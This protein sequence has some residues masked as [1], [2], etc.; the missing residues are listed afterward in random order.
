M[1]RYLKKRG[2]TYYVVRRVPEDVQKL[3]GSTIF[4]ESL[5]T[6]D[7]SLARK[8]RDERLKLLELEWAKARQALRVKT[9]GMLKADELRE[10]LELRHGL[11][12]ESDA[13][14]VDE[15]KEA[16]GDRT[17]ELYGGD[18]F[19]SDFGRKGS[20]KAGEFYGIASGE[21]TPT[22]LAV[23]QFLERANLKPSTK[24][25]YRKMLKLTMA[26]FPFLEDITRQRALKFLRGYAENTT[27]KAVSNLRTATRSLLAFHG[28]DP[29]VM[30]HHRIDAGKQAT[31]KGVWTDEEVLRLIGESVPT[32]GDQGWLRDAITVAAYSG[33]R[34]QEVCGLVYDADKDQLVVVEKKAKTKS[35]VRRVPCHP[36]AR[37]AVKR[38]VALPKPINE[39]TLTKQT[40]R[41]AAKLSIPQRI[42]IDGVQ[43][44]R[45]FHAFRHTFASKLTSLG[46]DEATIA[47]IV[48]HRGG[49]TARYAGKVDPEL[50]RGTVERVSYIKGYCQSIH[51][52][53]S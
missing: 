45:D 42:E 35:S 9:R 36:L 49:I 41:L 12:A 21:R 17:K 23:E 20:A 22:G 52:G 50:Y 3:V 24:S 28:L 40:Q 8:L 6:T 44:K 4:K 53:N 15:W 27:A 39:Q 46:V 18:V 1:N 26:E 32:R 14:L 11:L 37:E 34:R 38:I 5:K 47:R 31:D 19:E 10:A 29:S 51:N 30:A 2:R 16:I 48:G 13:A 43:H 25:L 7:L 33:L